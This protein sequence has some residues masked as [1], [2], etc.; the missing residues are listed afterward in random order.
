VQGGLIKLKRK[1]IIVGSNGQDGQLLAKHL[2]HKNYELTLLNR[3][4]FDITNVFDVS[5]IIEDVMPDEIYFLAAYH[6]SAE[7]IQE[8]DNLIF[9]KS[10]EINVTALSHF[11]D[12][13]AKINPK[14]RLFYASSSHIFSDYNGEIQ[15]ENTTK[16]PGNVYA[17]SKHVGMMACGYYRERKK[18]FASCGILYNHE[19]SV[20]SPNFLSRKV[21]KAA[22]EIKRKAKDKLILG[23]LD[24]R[25][26]WGYAPDYVDAMHRMLQLDMAADY[27]VASGELHTVRQLVEI[28]FNHVGLDYR[29]HVLEQ[30]GLVSKSFETRVG[31]PSRLIRDTGWQPTISFGEM[32][33][34]LVDTEM[35]ERSSLDI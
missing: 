20:R 33:R 16:S 23:N 17:I 24:A 31:D 30:D 25:V 1:A 4:N 15:N 3:S 5:N 8:S 13:I 21:T 28:A 6:H 14:A 12:S 35:H 18:V 9:K 22:V 27:I 2:T 7:D 29:N 32:I 34:Q 10:F 19:S 26:D 11:L